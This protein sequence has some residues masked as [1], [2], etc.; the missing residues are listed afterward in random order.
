MTKASTPPTSDTADLQQPHRATASTITD[1]ALDAL[2][3]QRDGLL[4]I[5]TLLLISGAAA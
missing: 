5:L 3:D 2:Y 4:R 1:P